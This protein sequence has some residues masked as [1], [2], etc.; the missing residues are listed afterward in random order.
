MSRRSPN[1]S[2]G[3][4]DDRDLHPSLD[5]W[6]GRTEARRIELG[7]KRF[8]AIAKEAYEKAVT[9]RADIK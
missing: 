4:E 7:A 8:V 1:S 5:G 9:L 2:R 3:T 6:A